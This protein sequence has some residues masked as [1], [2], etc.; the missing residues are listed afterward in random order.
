MIPERQRE[1]EGNNSPA[2]SH[3]KK[4]IDHG[5]GVRHNFDPPT[6]LEILDADYSNTFS[7]D[8]DNTILI[9]GFA[10]NLKFSERG[11]KLVSRFCFTSS[12]LRFPCVTAYFVIH[13][14]P[15]G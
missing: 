2:I 1:L 10:A 12:V 8:T 14:L 9:S 3:G 7:K 4:L 11:T 5:E 15:H 6:I 13:D